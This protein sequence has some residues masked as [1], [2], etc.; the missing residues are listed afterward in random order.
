MLNCEKKKRISII[1]FYSSELYSFLEL[2]KLL[3]SH[4]PE[5]S[6]RTNVSLYT[7]AYEIQRFQKFVDR[8]K[9][10][11]NELTRNRRFT[12]MGVRIISVGV[13]KRIQKF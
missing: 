9:R 11:G 10:N 3:I 7:Y 8:D 4:R 5:I 12:N 6:L 1:N 13:P 2:T